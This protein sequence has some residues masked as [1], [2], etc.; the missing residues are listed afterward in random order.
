MLPL[1]S[2]DVVAT[3]SVEGL[4]SKSENVNNGAPR[5]QFWE[6]YFYYLNQQSSLDVPHTNN[7]FYVDNTVIYCSAPSHKEALHNLQ[8]EFN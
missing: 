6:R 3:L 5:V 2:E 4:K 8:F 1:L 7:I